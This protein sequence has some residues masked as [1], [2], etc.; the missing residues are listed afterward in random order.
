MNDETSERIIKKYPNRRLYDTAISRYIT[1]EDI[2]KLVK[3]GIRFRV[4]D[5]KTEEDLTR[6][7]LLQ[8]IAEQEGKS[9]A[10]LT[11]ELLELIVRTYGDTM[12]GFMALYLRESVEVFLSQQKLM[13]E[14]MAS[15]IQTAPVSVFA[16]VA[17]QNLRLWQSMQESFLKSMSPETPPSDQ[18]GKPKKG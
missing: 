10:I 11:T 7:T 17:K 4:I 1:L 8:L 9:P 13:R 6:S 14:Q 5:A 12:Q 16:E 18:S 15:L 2:R 3:E